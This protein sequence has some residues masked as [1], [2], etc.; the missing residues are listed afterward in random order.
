MA[1]LGALTTFWAAQGLED[2]MSIGFTWDEI[3]IKMN[4]CAEGL[5]VDGS[6]LIGEVQAI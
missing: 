3:R 2:T 1:A 4:V 5:K 6:K